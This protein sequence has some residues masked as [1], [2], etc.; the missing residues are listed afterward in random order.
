MLTRPKGLGCELKP[1]SWKEKRDR[2][3]NYEPIVDYS[4]KNYRKEVLALVSGDRG[5]LRH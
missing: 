4:T 1:G 5:R 3:S 2:S